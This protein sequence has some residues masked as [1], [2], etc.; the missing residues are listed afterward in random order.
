MEE[1]ST[2]IKIDTEN[3]KNIVESVLEEVLFNT[4]PKHD[5]SGN[6]Y[7]SMLEGKPYLVKE[8]LITSYPIKNVVFALKSL[9]NLYD[10]GDV[11][12]RNKILY[13]LSKGQHYK[14]YNG[15]IFLNKYSQN[16][17]KRIEIRFSKDD[18]NQN[19]FDKYLLKYGWFC[20]VLRQSPDYDNIVKLIYEKKFDVDITEEV[21]KSRYL[22]HICPNIYL[23]KINKIGLKPKYSSWNSYSNPERIYFFRRKLSHNEFIMWVNNF[24]QEKNLEHT[25]NEGWSLLRVDLTTLINKPKFYLDPRMEDGIYT[26]DNISPES[27]TIIDYIKK[28]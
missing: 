18:F 17:T 19:D 23:N 16:D 1:L 26:M 11:S 9:F 6:M 15:V 21:M 22:Y 8:G 5:A 25:L 24:E 20:G 3:L 12:E 28:S 4:L 14:N 7:A 2:R 27:I 10:G 13:F